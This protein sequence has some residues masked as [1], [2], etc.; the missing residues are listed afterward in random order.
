MSISA[1]SVAGAIKVER[2]NKL[3]NNNNLEKF[4][5]NSNQLNDNLSSIKINKQIPQI[6]FK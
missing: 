4:L 1:N 5:Q 2:F 3:N 6:N